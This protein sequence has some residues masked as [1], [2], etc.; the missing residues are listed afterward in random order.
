M[1]FSTQDLKIKTHPS[2]Q[3]TSKQPRSEILPSLPCRGIVL[4]PSGSGK[5]VVLVDLILRHYR[6]L[7]ERIYIFSPSVNLDS[8][9]LP[10]RKY[11]EEEP[12][13]D[14]KEEPSFFDVWDASAL[15]DIY[16]TQ[17]QVIQEMKKRKLKTLS[18]ILI[19]VDDFADDPTI[20]HRQGG[21]TSGGSMLNTLFV[22]GRHSHISTIVS[23]QKLRLIGT[24]I[25]V[26]AQFLLVWR[27]RNRLELQALLEELSAV[28]P[29]KTLEEMYNLATEEPYSFWYIN[30]TAKKKDDMF[31]LRFEQRMVPSIKS[32]SEWEASSA[33]SQ[34]PLPEPPVANQQITKQQK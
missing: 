7:F 29:V 20:M 9:W 31:F 30:L 34:E 28:Y 14:Q 13:V 27:L 25:R 32:Q 21:Y 15:K 6:G 16:E 17:V 12:G 2:P 23:T 19:V 4:G 3:Y 18:N 11:I 33:T 22:R 26:N 10:V 5:T 8:T 24:T 1:P